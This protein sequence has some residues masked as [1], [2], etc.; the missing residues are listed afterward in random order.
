PAARFLG[1]CRRIRRNAGRHLHHNNTSNPK[2]I[3]PD[4]PGSERSD[5]SD[6][7][8]EWSSFRG[9]E[10]RIRAFATLRTRRVVGA[11]LVLPSLGQHPVARP[12][13]HLP[14]PPLGNLF[15]PS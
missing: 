12:P 9:S 1:T 15:H 8:V 10:R 14:S 3:P 4:T 7:Q 5:D 6:E 11:T 13:L 2:V